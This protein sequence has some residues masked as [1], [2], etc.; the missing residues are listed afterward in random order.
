LLTERIGEVF[1]HGEAS[2]EADFINKKGEATPYFLQVEKS[3]L[4]ALIA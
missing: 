3:F 4:T 2:V 1:I